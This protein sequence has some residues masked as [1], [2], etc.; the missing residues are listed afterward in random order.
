MSCL[1]GSRITWDQQYVFK[2]FSLSDVYINCHPVSC[3][4]RNLNENITLLSSVLLSGQISSLVWKNRM[5]MEE[6]IGKPSQS[7]L[8]TSHNL[9]NIFVSLMKAS[10]YISQSLLPCQWSA[11]G[12]FT[13]KVL[14]N[15][16]FFLF[17]I[18]VGSF[19]AFWSNCSLSEGTISGIHQYMSSLILYPFI[20]EPP[21]P[22][23]LPW[24]YISR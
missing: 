21:N 11:L 14:M 8:L 1:V 5:L 6:F 18:S 17:N 2:G 13:F 9:Q 22:Q 7:L 12:R 23:V 3:T 20:Q 19:V 24:L 16:H 10:I 15:L 4:Y